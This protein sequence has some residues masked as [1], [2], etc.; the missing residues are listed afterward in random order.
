MTDKML[1][2]PSPRIVEAELLDISSTEIRQ[3]IKDG[4]GIRRMVPKAVAD[5]IMEN[6]LYE[7]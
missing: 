3:R 2:A 4:K 5:F 6:S 7:K 1:G